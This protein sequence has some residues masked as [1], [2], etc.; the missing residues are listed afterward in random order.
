MENCHSS[1]I[2]PERVPGYKIC[3]GNGCSNVAKYPLRILYLNKI[4]WF[5]D[6]CKNELLN[7]GLVM[8]IKSVPTF[9]FNHE[10]GSGTRNEQS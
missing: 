6:A 9:D 5:C 8:E 2:D 1:P 10:G 4:A 3:A 7:E